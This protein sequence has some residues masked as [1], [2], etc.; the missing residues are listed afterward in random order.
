MYK[1]FIGEPTTLCPNLVVIT[2]CS[3]STSPPPPVFPK[4][5]HKTHSQQLKPKSG[6]CHQFLL[7]L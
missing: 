3:H 4:R 7:F 6:C 5:V 2:D 1:V